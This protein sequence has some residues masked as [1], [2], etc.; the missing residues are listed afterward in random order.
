MWF[1]EG[2]SGPFYSC[3]ACKLTHGA[4]KFDGTFAGH[5]MHERGAPL[6]IPCD[7]ETKE[8]RHAAHA[9][10]DQLWRTTD[11]RNR[12]YRRLAQRM[13]MA[14]DDCHVAK[15]GKSRC[16]ELLQLLRGQGIW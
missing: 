16:R 3:Q 6:G 5:K 11:E 13:G 12:V 15:F 4:H 8:L 14:V 9:E 1:S 7:A 10:L 2:R